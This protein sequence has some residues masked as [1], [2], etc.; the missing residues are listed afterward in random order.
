MPVSGGLQVSYF[1]DERA[2]QDRAP[3]RAGDRVEALVRARPVRNFG[4]PGAFDYRTFLARE[5]IDLTA[6]LRSLELLEKLPGPPPTLAH[7]LARLRGRLLDEVDAMFADSEN[8]AAVARAMLL[9][10][11][12]FLD[13]EQVE[14]FR[15]TRAYHVLVVGGLHVGALV[16]V[17]LW[18]GRKA[19]LP[20]VTRTLVTIAALGAYVMIVEDRPPIIRAA[21]VATVYLLGRLMFRRTALLNA[22]GVAAL[23]ILLLRPSELKDASFQLS[24]LAAGIIGGIA[25]PWLARTAERYRRALDHL[26]DVTR[27]GAHAPRV[28][29]FRLDTRAASNWLAAR[30]PQRISR[31]APS[32]I[33]LPCRMTL[34]VWELIV[35]SA[36]IQIGMLPL[37]AQY[38]HRISPVGLFANVS[39]VLLTGVIV[40]FGFAALSASAVWSAVGHAFGRALGAL[41]AALLVS[42][43]WFSHWSWASYRVPSP[44]ASLLAAFFAAAVLFS[45]AILLAQTL[46]YMGRRCYCAH[47]CRVDRRLSVFTSAQPRTA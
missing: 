25:A 10:D 21:L 44:P 12:S 33:A 34:R 1:F 35:I 45:G 38:F 20:L 4:D 40:P 16:V 14:P 46:G 32:A 7:R 31:F 13:R 5:N 15:E 28:A 30:L 43:D 29:Q 11:R 23:A 47:A 42:V 22:I 6:S 3:L 24:F 19:R 17:L 8:R 26:G 27:D 39:A 41:I 18:A 9:G 36:A 37:M 2:A